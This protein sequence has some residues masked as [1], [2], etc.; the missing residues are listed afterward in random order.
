MIYYHTP[1]AT[2]DKAQ[3]NLTNE[4][5]GMRS[6]LDTASVASVGWGDEGTPTHGIGE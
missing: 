6:M 2:K 3:K 1:D 4:F 5:T